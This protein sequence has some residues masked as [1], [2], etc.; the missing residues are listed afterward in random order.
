MP[1]P[2]TPINLFYESVNLYRP[3]NGITPLIA[4]VITAGFWMP[5]GLVGRRGA[6]ASQQAAGLLA[7]LGRFKA[8]ALLC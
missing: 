1:V 6:V 7:T 8:A 4:P 3:E 2:I 5:F